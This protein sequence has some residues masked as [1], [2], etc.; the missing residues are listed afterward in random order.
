MLTTARQL[1]EVTIALWFDLEHLEPTLGDHIG[2]LILTLIN[3]LSQ[4]SSHNIPHQLPRDNSQYGLDE[5][6]KWLTF[7]SL[8]WLSIFCVFVIRFK[9]GEVVQLEVPHY[10]YIVSSFFP[11]HRKHFVQY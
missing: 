5:L 2:L 4:L 8:N 10:Q 11:S 7:V 3:A 6:A 9:M 1:I